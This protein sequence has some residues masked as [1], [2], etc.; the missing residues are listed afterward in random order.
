MSGYHGFPTPF[1]GPGMGGITNDS[2]GK[3]VGGDGHGG[4][5]EQADDRERNESN[6]HRQSYK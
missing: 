1:E 4:N 6:R 5:C 3:E 2:A